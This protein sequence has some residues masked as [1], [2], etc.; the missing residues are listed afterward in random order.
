[1]NVITK[2]VVPENIHTHTTEG[3]LVCT[4]PT[5]QEFPFQGVVDDPPPPQ[6]FPLFSNM[7]CF[8]PWKIQMVLF[9]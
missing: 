4:P 3:F 5:P 8:T 1:M 9:L 6:E 7:D 2:C